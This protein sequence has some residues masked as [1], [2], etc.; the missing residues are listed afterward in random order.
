MKKR[1]WGE[2]QEQLVK[3]YLCEVEDRKRNKIYNRLR[4]SFLKMI[5]SILMRYYGKYISKQYKT[6]E[7]LIT[8]CES[9]IVEK[10]FPMYNPKYK[11]FAYLGTS[12]KHYYHDYFL[13]RS[14]R[15]YN[16]I[17]I[18]NIQDE[19]HFAGDHQFQFLKD[20]E[21]NILRSKAIN[22]IVNLKK[23][24]TS[25]TIHNSIC[26]YVIELI[27]QGEFNKNYASYFLL[28]KTGFKVSSLTVRLRRMNLTGL[29]NTSNE[30]EFYERL[31]QKAKKK[32][33]TKTDKQIL[34]EY[35]KKSKRP[36]NEIFQIQDSAGAR[37]K[38]IAGKKKKKHKMVHK[39]L[40]LVVP[41]KITLEE[42]GG[43]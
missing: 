1:Y 19:E 11:A 28:K 25:I 14:R 29:I 7:E 21:L 15:N 24:D 30:I 31:I 9:D 33:N 2:L 38:R 23:E 40:G 6:V 3:D 20:E 4:P 10:A 12:A 13:I 42:Y 18:E 35:R 43:N 22:K 17:D 37:E 26:D 8:D 39:N 41:D 32:D 36:D 34:N 27:E 16:I 5:E